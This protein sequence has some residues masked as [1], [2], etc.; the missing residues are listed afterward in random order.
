MAIPY[1][2][3]KAQRWAAVISSL[4]TGARYKKSIQVREV[5]GPFPKYRIN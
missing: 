2:S 3:T 5:K 1:D 4:M